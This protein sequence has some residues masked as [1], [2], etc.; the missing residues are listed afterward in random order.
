M[1]T[2]ELVLEKLEKEY[3]RSRYEYPNHYRSNDKDDVIFDKERWK[4]DNNKNRRAIR[5]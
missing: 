4:D 3:S 1:I 2:K 5:R